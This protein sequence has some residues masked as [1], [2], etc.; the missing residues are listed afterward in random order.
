MCLKYYIAPL[1]PPEHTETHRKATGY[2]SKCQNVNQLS[3]CFHAHGRM[4]DVIQTTVQCTCANFLWSR[5]KVCG[6][7]VQINNLFR[8]VSSEKDHYCFFSEP[9]TITTSTRYCLHGT[10]TYHAKLQLLLLLC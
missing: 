2:I 9:T 1:G 3:D 7:T 10:T 6:S 4:Y 8:I 5:S